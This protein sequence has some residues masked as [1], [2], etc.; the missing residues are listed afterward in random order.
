MEVS[1]KILNGNMSIKTTLV[2][3]KGKTT[4]KVAH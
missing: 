3:E 2:C 1:H 4:K